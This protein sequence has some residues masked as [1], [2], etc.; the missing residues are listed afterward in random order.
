[1]EFLFAHQTEKKQKHFNLFQ[2]NSYAKNSHTAFSDFITSCSISK[3]SKTKSHALR[4]GFGS[5]GA[6]T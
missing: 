3:Q 4:S 6:S 2:A 1:M 5:E